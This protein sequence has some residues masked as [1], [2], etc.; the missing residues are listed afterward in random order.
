MKVYLIDASVILFALLSEKA[1]ISS[2]L[3]R[4]LQDKQKNKIKLYDLDLTKY[5]VLN[6]LRFSLK[7]AELSREAFSRYVD[8]PIDHFVFTPQQGREALSLAYQ[9]QATVYDAAYHVVARLMQ[10]TFLTADKEYYLKTRHLGHIELT[11]G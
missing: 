6:G 2:K 5:E 4:L 10:G 1:R 8:L 7:D 9:C 3:K 11:N